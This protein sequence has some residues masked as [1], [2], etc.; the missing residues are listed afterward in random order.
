VP[1]DPL[2]EWAVAQ[3]RAF[4]EHLRELRRAAG[5]SQIQLGE[6]A[7]R[8]HKTIHRW[9]TGA[10]WPDLMDLI[11]LAHGLGVSLVELVQER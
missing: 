9:E 8:D 5:L 11:L 4:G 1:L 3:Q 7:G 10:T 6:R 2:P